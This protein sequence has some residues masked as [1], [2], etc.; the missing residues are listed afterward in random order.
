LSDGFKPDVIHA[1][2]GWPSYFFCRKTARAGHTPFLATVHKLWRSEEL[3]RDS[4]MGLTLRHADWV[5]CVSKA[6]MKEALQAIPEIEPRSSCIYHG[7]DIPTSPSPCPPTTIPTAL[8]VGRLAPEKGVDLV[9]QAWPAVQE[10]LPEARLVIVGDGDERQALEDS[11]EHLGITETVTFRG[12]VSSRDIRSIMQT[13]RVLIMPSRT[14]G[15]GLVGV[16]AAAAARPLIASRVGGL[17]E[18]VEDGRTGLLVQP[19]N[20]E[21]LQRAVIDLLGDLERARTMGREAW[22]LANERFS[23]TGCVEAYNA[24]YRTLLNGEV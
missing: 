18:V 21:E 14:E 2:T 19:G 15:L 7:V 17:T 3:A 9:L 6:S 13:A 1:C 11:A 10:R 12:W 23:W 20:V 22:T 8:F 24:L 16:E 4:V 5:V